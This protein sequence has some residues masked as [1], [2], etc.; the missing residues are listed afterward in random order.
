MSVLFRQLET[1]IKEIE[2]DL[3]QIKKL[4]N[5]LEE[6][7]NALR[8]KLA[9]FAGYEPKGE[10]QEQASGGAFDNLKKI[11]DDGFHICNVHFG[12]LR[13]EECLFCTAFLER[14]K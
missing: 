10:P 2:I 8:E 7:N 13:R 5:Y 3:Q 14:G 1:R 9:V 12:R 6:E 11:Y 4:V